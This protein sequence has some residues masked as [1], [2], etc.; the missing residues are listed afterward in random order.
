M[1][2]GFHIV[3]P[4]GDDYIRQTIAAFREIDPDHLIP[5][6]CTGDRFYDLAR[7][8]DGRQGDPLRGGDALHFRRAVTFLRVIFSENRPCATF[9]DHAPKKQ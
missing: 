6:H 4:L 3:P 8:G 2:G 7:A 1:I 5:G 9:R